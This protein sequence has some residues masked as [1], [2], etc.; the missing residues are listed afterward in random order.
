M[1]TRFKLTKGEKKK[2]TN[3]LYRRRKS[4]NGSVKSKL[5]STKEKQENGTDWSDRSI[6]ED[7]H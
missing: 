5:L 6:E 7:L 4:V 2:T 1:Q 3:C